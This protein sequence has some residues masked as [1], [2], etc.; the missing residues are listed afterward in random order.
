MAWTDPKIDWTSVHGVA[1]T[2]LNAMGA[3]LKWLR[4]QHVDLTTGV[5]GA[6]SAATA[7]KIL[8]RD[9]SG[10]AKVAAPSAEDEIALKSNVTAEASA[11]TSADNT[12][13]SQINAIPG[14]YLPLAGGTMTGA[15]VGHVATDY[16]TARFRNILVGT[17]VPTTEGNNG[18]VYMRYEV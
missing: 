15:A 8:I 13:Q 4:E 10:R 11:R 14:T 18:D 16:T 5:H 7:S 12:L 1:D 3:N 17:A 2:D 6:V 9:A